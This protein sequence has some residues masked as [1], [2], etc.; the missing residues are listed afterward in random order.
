MSD[1]NRREIYSL[2]RYIK[3]KETEIRN[4][5]GFV[6]TTHNLKTSEKN[7]VNQDLKELYAQLK[8]A[9]DLLDEYIEDLDLDSD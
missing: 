5:L 9:H 6:C 8:Q 1:R 4:T 7:D 3:D 2:P